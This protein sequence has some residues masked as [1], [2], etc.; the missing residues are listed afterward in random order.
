[1]DVYDVVSLPGFGRPGEPQLA[2]HS[3][4]FRAARS[5]LVFESADE[6]RRYPI[7][8]ENWEQAP[9]AEM[10]RLLDQATAVSKRSP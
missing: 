7:I 6:K 2:P 1:W 4:V 8:P 9:A 3:E 5:W 10:Q